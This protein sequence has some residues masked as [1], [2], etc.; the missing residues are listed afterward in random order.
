[1]STAYMHA[2]LLLHFAG[3]PINEENLKKV[4]EAAGIP[5]DEARVKVLTAALSEVN[6]E[7]AIKTAPTLAAPVAAPAAAPAEAK[8]AEEKKEEKK[9]EEE[10]KKEEEALSGLGALFG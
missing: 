2:A 7:E 9:E 10:E 1:M 8:P 5:P 4:L 6:I 3:Q